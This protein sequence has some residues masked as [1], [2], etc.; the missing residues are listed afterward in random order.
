MS[1]AKSQPRLPLN[2][3]VFQAENLLAA[4]EYCTN[5]R[6]TMGMCEGQSNGV[7]LSNKKQIKQL[8][9]FVEEH[10]ED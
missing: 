7:F 3:T 2:L 9:T 6:I 10:G 5:H 1:N 4:L 8:E